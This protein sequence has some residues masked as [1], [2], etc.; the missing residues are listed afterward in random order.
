L[1]VAVTRS[2][3]RAFNVL[4]LCLALVRVAA[5]ADAEPPAHCKTPRAAVE[6]L[7]GWLAPEHSNPAKAS[8]CLDR[9]GRTTREARELAQQVKVVYEAR[10]LRIDSSKIPDE[11]GWVNPDTKRTSLAPHP[12]LPSVVIERQADGMWRWT[13][14]SL[15]VVEELYDDSLIAAE[16]GFVQKLPSWM[17]VKAAGVELW[18]ALAVVLLFALGVLFRQV[19]RLFVRNR[20][21]RLAERRGKQLA[22]DIA[23]VFA[24]PGAALLGALMLRLTYPELG[25]PLTFA[26]ALSTTVR[27]LVA[28]A[29]VL[30]LYRLV[31]VLA[32][33]LAL[34]ADVT[35][36]RLD[37]QFVPLIRK[38][39][40][41]VIIAVGLL[42]L[43][44]NLGVNVGSLLAGLGIGGLALALA[45][46]DTIAN[47]FGSVMI[48]A[49]RPFR[50]G[51]WV[52]VEGAE[53]RIEEVGF[54]ST[55]IRTLGDS[56]VT[57]PNAKFMEA[58]IENFGARRY[59]RIETTLGVTYDTDVSR[60]QALVEA[61]RAIIRANPH[62]RKEKYDVHFHAFGAH[63]LDILLH[64]YISAATWSDEL[65]VRHDLFLEI[66]RAAE[67]LGVRFAFP[68]QTLHVESLA[69]MG[70][71]AESSPAVSNEQL[72]EVIAAYGP[73]GERARPTAL[74]LV[75]EG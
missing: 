7:F 31:D 30:A 21:A 47:F 25:L 37:D 28:F 6:S 59:R 18:Q 5:A 1:E 2:S 15:D 12:T 73:G 24:T 74:R 32:T 26:L 27:A 23:K 36:S 55:R 66:L 34:R 9:V 41:A 10:A 62:T 70:Q 52:S 57:L 68:T 56:I 13:R 49:D 69:T 38:L 51:D 11:P 16:R 54:R 20:L 58:K 48:F 42:V 67:D 50:I 19:I 60:I 43:L 65:A 8:R 39:L 44:Q 33:H 46:K 40:K 4:L 45:A 22:A 72:A 63:S 14:S 71:P 75:E 3:I 64:F 53:G 61:I 35:E 29:L 17:R